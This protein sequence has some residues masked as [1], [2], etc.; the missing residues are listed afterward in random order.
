M[1]NTR[2]PVEFGAKHPLKEGFLPDWQSTEING[3]STMANSTPVPNLPTLSAEEIHANNLTAFRI[4][5]AARHALYQGLQALARGNGLLKRLTCAS[6]EEYA[7]KYFR[8]SR[9]K[10][11]EAIRVEDALVKLPLLT[12]AFQIGAISWTAVQERCFPP[13]VPPRG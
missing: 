13:S 1:Y 9:A 10:T 7:K 3:G 5:N 2:Q 6:I 11:H 4:G 12:T 8:M